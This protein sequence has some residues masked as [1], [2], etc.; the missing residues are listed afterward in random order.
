MARLTIREQGHKVPVEDNTPQR[1]NSGKRVAGK[2]NRVSKLPTKQNRHANT[3][4][5][6][7][8]EEDD[9]DD[10]PAPPRVKDV[11]QET[12]TLHKSVIVAETPIVGNTDFLKLTEFNYIEFETHN[13]RKLHDAATK[14]GFEFAIDSSTAPISAKGV[15]VMDNI[16]IAIEDASNWKK[17][18]KGIERWM[19][20]NK[21]EITVKLAIVYRKTSLPES[22]DDDDD[23][24]P[25]KKV[26]TLLC[27]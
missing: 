13:I 24:P 26:V 20:S 17:V 14:G 18:E 16:I 5:E 4:V 12:Y 7:E 19:L 23:G 21:K 27:Y 22:D 3:V 9:E 6:E 25:R 2:N 8:V 11:S 1:S 10:E 15:R